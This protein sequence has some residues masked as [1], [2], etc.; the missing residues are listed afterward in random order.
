MYAAH[1]YKLSIR[2]CRLTLVNAG[3]C[4]QVLQGQSKLTLVANMLTADLLNYI[5]ATETYA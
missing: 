3:D 1:L 5:R 4:T 2:I